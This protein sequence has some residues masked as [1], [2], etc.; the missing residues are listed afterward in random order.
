MAQTV[1]I[2]LSAEERARLLV[3]IGD[4]N[5]SQKHAR[6]ARIILH[7]GERMPVLDIARRSDVSRSD[8]Q[9]RGLQKA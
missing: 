2:I 6:R 7:S 5:L 3:I 1:S 8:V 9:N 4:R